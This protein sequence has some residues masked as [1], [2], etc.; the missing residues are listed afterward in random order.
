MEIWRRFNLNGASRFE[1]PRRIYKTRCAFQEHEFQFQISNQDYIIHQDVKSVT[2]LYASDMIK[3]WGI[4]RAE[5]AF[6]VRCFK[7]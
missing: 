6:K 1:Y 7:F 4:Q 2:F 3:P 5:C